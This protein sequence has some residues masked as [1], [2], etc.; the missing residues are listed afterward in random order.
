[1]VLASHGDPGT[2][3]KRLSVSVLVIALMLPAKSLSAQSAPAGTW[4]VNIGPNAKNWGYVG[5]TK[6][7]LV[8]KHFSLFVTGGFGTTLIGAGGAFYVTSF[9]ENSFV[10]SANAG[11][12]AAYANAAY[13]LKAGRRG[14]VTAGVS[15]G[16]YFLQHKG[17]LPILSYELRF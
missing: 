4:S 16:Y 3:M 8:N 2:L 5:I 10:F 9:H 1:M 15:Y 12:V 6:D 17:P 13:Q 7:F 14:F 11:L